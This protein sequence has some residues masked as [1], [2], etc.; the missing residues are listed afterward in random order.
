MTRGKHQTEGSSGQIVKVRIARARGKPAVDVFPSQQVEPDAFVG[1]YG[2]QLVVP[3]YNFSQLS[4]LAEMHPVHGAALEQKAADILGQGLHWESIHPN[5]DQGQKDALNAWLLG[6]ES[7]ATLS[8]TLSAALQDYETFG[9]GILEVLRDTNSKARGLVHA[10]SQTFRAH[11]DRKRLVQIINERRIWFRCWGAYD[12]KADPI[13]SASGNRAPAGTSQ[14]KLAND[15]LV[16]RKASRRSAVYGVPGYVSAIGHI[17][18]SLAARDYNVAFFGNAREPRYMFIVEGPNVAEVDATLDT[19]EEALNTQHGEPH[20]NLMVG[21][22]GGC[23]VQVEKLTDVGNDE[24]FTRLTETADG[25]ILI[26]HRIPADRLGA[27]VRGTLGGSVTKEVSEVYR[28]AVIGPMQQII[29][30]RLNKFIL[31]EYGELNNL[32]ELQWKLALDPLDLS[33]EPEDVKTAVEL[34]K[35][36]LITLNEGRARV[37]YEPIDDGDVTL[38]VYL[39]AHGIT[40]AVQNRA[41]DRLTDAM[42]D[43][44][45]VIDS[46]I[47]RLVTSRDMEEVPNAS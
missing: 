11:I 13:L 14:D 10:P 20:C 24:H 46:A 21:A 40:S 37:G 3:P 36:D 18:M 17:A 33:D 34:V 29:V 31:K 39:Q 28:D 47:Q 26:A 32:S 42:H 22:I 45:D 43:R 7:E 15:L 38:S 6:L 8:E 27:V 1:Q 5:P 35:F 23:K 25:K 41:G 9:W 12:K 4:N 19:I 44:L 16:F 30:D 2:T